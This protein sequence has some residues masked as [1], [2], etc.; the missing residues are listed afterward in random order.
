[1][2]AELPVFRKYSD[3]RMTCPNIRIIR[4]FYIVQKNRKA[5]FFRKFQAI[6]DHYSY[7]P[8]ASLDE[9]VPVEICDPLYHKSLVKL[10]QYLEQNVM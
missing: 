10:R 2:R 8:L 5:Y 1:M 4:I 3:I 6:Q 9:S 7:T